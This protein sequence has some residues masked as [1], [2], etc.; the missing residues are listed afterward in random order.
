VNAW[1]EQ[2]P[3]NREQAERIFNLSAA[4]LISRLEAIDEDNLRRVAQSS[5][6]ASAIWRE[7]FKKAGY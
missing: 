6:R 4:M 7:V 5:L 1:S 2:S 3:P